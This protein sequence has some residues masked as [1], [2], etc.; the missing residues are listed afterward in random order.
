M[1]RT[2]CFLV[3]LKFTPPAALFRA[4]HDRLGKILILTRSE[5]F[6][7]AIIT[8]LLIEHI[9]PLQPNQMDA[10][11]TFLADKSYING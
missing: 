9:H 11:N 6:L 1:K 7:A 3:K 8:L 4:D 5:N 10:I 2:N